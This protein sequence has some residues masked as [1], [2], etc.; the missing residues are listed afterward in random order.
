MAALAERLG[1]ALL[2]A[3]RGVRSLHRRVTEGAPRASVRAIVRHEGRV[4]MVRET[5]VPWVWVLPGGEA[6]RGER[7]EDCA[8]REVREETG[9]AMLDA[10]VVPGGLP[11]QPDAI[12][13]EGTAASP[14]IIITRRHE[15]WDARWVSETDH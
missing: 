8:T 10:R 4:L 1:V 7:P 9:V 5:L 6:K 13:V 14:A 2:R 11:E 15:I 3:G 12:V